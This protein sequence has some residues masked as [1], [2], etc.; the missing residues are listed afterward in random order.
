MSSSA[1]S[2][3]KLCHSED[4]FQQ[5]IRRLNTSPVREEADYVLYWM[6]AARRTSFN[7]AL[8]R[9]IAWAQKLTLPLVVFEPLRVGDSWASDRL[10]RFVIDGMNDNIRKFSHI[11]VI[12]YPYIEPKRDAAKGLLVALAAHA[13]VVVSDDYPCFFLPRMLAAAILPVCLEVVDSNG[14]LPLRSADHAFT[15]AFHYRRHMQKAFPIFA[16]KTP[17]A[18]PL[19]TL[20]LPT[21]KGLLD[22]I[23]KRWPLASEDILAGDPQALARLPIDHSVP[24]S[25]MRGGEMAARAAL[26][27]FLKHGLANYNEAH[28]EP[29]VEGTSR[30]SPYLHFG[31]IGVHEIFS[32][33]MKQEK[34]SLFK[35]G[36]KPN[37]ARE[38]WW[39]VSAGAE[40]FLDQLVTWRELAF[41]QCA[42]SPK[43]YDRYDSLPAWA[44]ETLAKH[45]RDPRPHV[46]TRT[47]L[48]NGKTH[49]PLWNAA[50]GQLRTEGWFHNYMRMLWAKKILE[51]SRTPREALGHMIA[52]MDRWSL[53]GRDP[54]A[55]AGYFWT[56]GRY[57]RPWPERPIYGTVRSMSSD[58]TA[59]K[60]S[61]KGYIDRYAPAKESGQ[62]SLI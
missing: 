27:K 62:M 33:V 5:R 11:P 22:A 48:E 26:A 43:D 18:N 30:L 20:D 42:F 28:N 4:A 9:A 49:D 44:K 8:D 7:F 16:D 14:I 46:Y 12:Y 51:W 1:K 40:A 53:D 2:Q 38:G 36:P 52:I 25:P 59:R 17:Q 45:E 3:A 23:Q 21:P 13:S 55:Y 10:H 29:E 35:L 54:N 34:W 56:L 50:M 41:N 39:G 19:K 61:V 24:V 37:G 6:I 58:N 47:Q 15:A 32:A 60:F 31:H 57:D